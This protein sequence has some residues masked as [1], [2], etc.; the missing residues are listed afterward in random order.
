MDTILFGGVN[1][2]EFK[3][4]ILDDLKSLLQ[5]FKFPQKEEPT[6]DL[7]TRQEVAEMLSIDLSTVHNWSKQGKLSSY[8]IGNRVYYKHSEIEQAIVKLN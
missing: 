2:Q 8:G 7:L 5:E 4:E 6:T 3:K 1:P